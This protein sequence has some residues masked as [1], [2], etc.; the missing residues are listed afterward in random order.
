MIGGSV[1][2]A[3]R[4]RGLVE[5]VVGIGRDASRLDEGVRH[6]AIDE[7]TTDPRRG[8]AAAEVVVICT[9][10]PQIV[11]DVRNAAEWGPEGVL[12][13]DAG[14]TKREI[15]EQVAKHDR[16]RAVFVG[17]HPI[18]GSERKGVAFA[19]ANLFVNRSCVLTPTADT[20]PDRL[21]RAREFWGGLGCRMIETTPEDHDKALA[22]TSHLPHALASALAGVIPAEILAMAAGAYRDG[23][24]VAGSDAKL[25]SGIFRANREAVLEAMTAFEKRLSAFKDA[26]VAD[27]EPTLND[28]WDSAKAL[29]ARFDSENSAV[30]IES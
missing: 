25:W 6:G 29:R 1:G 9:P 8:V 12:V 24:R 26:L 15:V 17:G 19:D 21:Q 7:G 23:T 4:E 30:G 2:K 22:L 11:D 20:P 16:S 14:S 10:V 5:R 3:L 27:D 18:A 28:L 13:T